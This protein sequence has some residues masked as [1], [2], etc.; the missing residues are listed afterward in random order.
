[1]K[2]I[3][4]PLIFLLII[5]YAAMAVIIGD[6]AGVLDKVVITIN[7]MSGAE[8]NLTGSTIFIVVG[9]FLLFIEILKATKIDSASMVNNGLSMGVFVIALVLFIVLP[10][11]GNSTFFIITMMALL[12]AIAGFTITAVTA[13]RDIGFG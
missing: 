1:M 11:Y 2:F 12:D 4:F 7:L 9:L 5:V 6:M 3:M 13:R 10:D 8:W